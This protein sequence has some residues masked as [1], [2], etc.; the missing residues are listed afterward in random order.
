MPAP[1]PAASARTLHAFLIASTLI[2][3]V[4]ALVAVRSA[5]PT[6]SG[7]VPLELAALLIGLSLLTMVYL[8]RTRI[9]PR[10]SAESEDEWWRA[11]LGKA[12]LLWS[13]LEF[14]ALVGALTL[15]LTRHVL[16]FSLLA[17]LALAGLFLVAPAR[18]TGTRNVQG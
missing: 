17:L 2:V 18:L 9:L 3:S 15:F 11:H 7:V 6:A 16:G 10:A 8:L 4:G 5:G 13:L 14:S 12:L 1:G